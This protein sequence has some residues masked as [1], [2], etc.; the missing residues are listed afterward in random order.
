VKNSIHT[1]GSRPFFV[2]ALATPIDCVRYGIHRFKPDLAL[3]G[4]NHGANT[5]INAMCSGTVCAAAMAGKL[6]VPVMAISM[7][8]PDWEKTTW[9]PARLAELIKKLRTN[10]RYKDACMHV[11]IPPNWKRDLAIGFKRPSIGLYTAIAPN[12]KIKLVIPPETARILNSEVIM[13][14][15]GFV[16]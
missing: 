8:A 7:H 16:C 3:V 10:F 15:I 13:W 12:G 14:P 2:T 5:G 9:T 6:G 1:E 11:N 4:V